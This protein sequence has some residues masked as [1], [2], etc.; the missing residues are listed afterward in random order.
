MDVI[1]QRISS[2]LDNHKNIPPYSN[3][4]VKSVCSRAQ[5]HNM[6]GIEAEGRR[7]QECLVVLLVGSGKML[8]CSLPFLKLA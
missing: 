4:Q 3:P 8:H 7:K 2:P 6:Y 5:M 1:N